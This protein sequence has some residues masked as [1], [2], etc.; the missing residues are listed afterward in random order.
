MSL[1][2]VAMLISAALGVLFLVT[3]FLVIRRCY[4]TVPAG[5]ALVVDRGR[6]ERTVSFTGQVVYPGIQRAELIDV[7]ARTVRIERRASNPLQTKDGALLLATATFVLRVGRAQEDVLKVAET[8]GAERANDAGAVERLFSPMFDQALEAVAGA[9]TAA[10]IL[11]D[12]GRFRDEIIQ[13]IGA[14]L[15]GWWL[16]DLAVHDVRS[17]DG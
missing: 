3:S 9:C 6:A 7:T 13:F 4:V 14:D 2:L 10:D 17:A 5:W 8:L 12:R 11:G 16:D 15:N 1:S